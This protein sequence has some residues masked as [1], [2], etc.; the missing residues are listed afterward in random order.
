MKHA[1]SATQAKLKFGEI[2]ADVAFGRRHVQI[3]KQGKKLAV[4]IPQEDYELFLKLMELDQKAS[5]KGAFEELLEWRDA[6]PLD[7]EAPPAVK[8]IRE[9]RDRD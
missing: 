9:L 1:V 6:L 3:E 4:M 2:L 7:P 8:I 5:R